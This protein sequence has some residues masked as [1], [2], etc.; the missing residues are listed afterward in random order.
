MIRYNTVQ[1]MRIPYFFLRTPR[2]KMQLGLK[3]MSFSQHR[4]SIDDQLQVNKSFVLYIIKIL[5][6]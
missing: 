2:Y 1:A 5:N 3:Q 6:S 4:R